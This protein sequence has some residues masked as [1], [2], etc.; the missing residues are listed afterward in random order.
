[1]PDGTSPIPSDGPPDTS[2]SGS[3]PTG[4]TVRRESGDGRRADGS[5]T[6]VAEVRSDPWSRIVRRMNSEVEEPVG[7]GA[8]E[9]PRRGEE[10]A[11]TIANAGRAI[12]A[13]AAAHGMDGTCHDA[14]GLS[15]RNRATA[16]GDPPPPLGGRCG[17]VGA[18]PPRHAARRR[19]RDARG[20][21]RR[22]Y[23][24]RA[25]TGTLIDV[26]ALSGWV[27]L[28]QSDEWVEFSILSS[29]FDDGAAPSRS[30]TASCAS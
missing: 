11:R 17:A 16:I 4:C 26:S 23:A 9:A 22:T 14:S 15:Y 19:A 18:R 29:R 8:R 20:S 27:W 1:M 7:R 3:R 2:R 5:W 10:P 12:C 28:E 24:L 21:P 25:K 13:Y 6:A 30:R